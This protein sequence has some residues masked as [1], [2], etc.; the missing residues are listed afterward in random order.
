MQP[1]ASSEKLAP[2]SWPGLAQPSTT[3]R[4]SDRHFDALLLALLVCALIVAVT[5]LC[6]SMAILPLADYPNHLA[7]L[8]IQSHIGADTYLADYYRLFWHFQPNLSLEAVAYVLS[9]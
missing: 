4:V 8:F 1:M 5:W 7:R 3:L 6:L 2:P 9:P